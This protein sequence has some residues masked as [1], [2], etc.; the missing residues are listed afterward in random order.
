M[1]PNPIENGTE[2]FVH[3]GRRFIGPSISQKRSVVDARRAVRTEKHQTDTRALQLESLKKL[4]TLF[5]SKQNL[6]LTSAGLAKAKDCLLQAY[7]MP[8]MNSQWDIVRAYVYTYFERNQEKIDSIHKSLHEMF[9]ETHDPVY[10]AVSHLLQDF[11]NFF[12]VECDIARRLVDCPRSTGERSFDPWKYGVDCAAQ[13]L[14]LEEVMDVDQL[15]AGYNDPA[16]FSTFTIQ[17]APPASSDSESSEE[18]S[19]EET[20]SDN[21]TSQEPCSNVSR[22]AAPSPESSAPGQQAHDLYDY[23]PASPPIAGQ[24]RSEYHRDN[25]MSESNS[26]ESEDE[27]RGF[28]DGIMRYT[29]ASR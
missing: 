1:R 11:T 23:D 7:Y 9:E 14:V 3:L 12:F 5:S 22:S 15:L 13:D 8:K 26:S 28:G 17:T 21:R 19:V 6:C 29:R 20:E 27:S 4:E 18:A 24:P 25:E 2:L 16:N 10:W